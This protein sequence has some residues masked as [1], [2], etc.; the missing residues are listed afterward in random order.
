[1]KMEK[2]VIDRL[3]N[4]VRT[5]ELSI[6]A[7]HYGR[8]SQQLLSMSLRKAVI[9]ALRELTLFMRQILISEELNKLFAIPYERE[10][11]IGTNLLIAIMPGFE[12]FVS[13]CSSLP[14][15]TL[16]K[17][18]LEYLLRVQGE[19][20]ISYGHVKEQTPFNFR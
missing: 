9:E 15:E 20:L 18:M 13:D 8:S 16:R 17:E 14:V 5:A 1:M 7:Y 4:D 19:L 12:Q 11:E 10:S 2:E 3:R 6:R